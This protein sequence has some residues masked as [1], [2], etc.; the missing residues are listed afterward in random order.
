MLAAKETADALIQGQ[1]QSG[2][3]DN[4]IEFT[5]GPQGLS[6]SMRV[7]QCGGWD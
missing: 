7:H 2:G 3:W 4:R 1:L 6:I 5:A